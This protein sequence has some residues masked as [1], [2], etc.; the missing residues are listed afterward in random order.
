[1]FGNFSFLSF[2][3]K[4]ITIHLLFIDNIHLIIDL[5]FFM[6]FFQQLFILANSSFSYHWIHQFIIFS[7]IYLYIVLWNRWTGRCL[8]SH[9]SLFHF[10][11]FRPAKIIGKKEANWPK[12]VFCTLKCTVDV[13]LAIIFIHFTIKLDKNHPPS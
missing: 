1:M 13:I 6:Y 4:L 12:N 10:L 3:V 7:I 5:V 2:G 11:C 9:V 8:P